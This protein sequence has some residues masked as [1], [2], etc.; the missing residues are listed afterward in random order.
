MCLNKTVTNP[1]VW[2]CSV[3]KSNTERTE[4]KG[5]AL[6]IVLKCLLKLRVKGKEASNI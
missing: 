5:K 3:W 6:S 1:H 2:Q 4:S